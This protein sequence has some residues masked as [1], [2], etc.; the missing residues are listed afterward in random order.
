MIVFY[1]PKIVKR[2]RSC[3]FPLSLLHVAA[4]LPPDQYE[5][6][7]GNIDPNPRS[8][9]AA[10]VESRN[11]I[12]VLAVTVMPGP[13]VVSALRDCQW[14]RRRFP[15]IP[16]LWGGYFPSLYSRAALNAPYVDFLVRG[17]G[18][19][20]FV[21]F[22]RQHRNGKNYAAIP[23]FSFKRHGEQVHNS[24]DPWK[25]PDEFPELL[26]YQKIKAEDYIHPSFL[27]KR[28]A[29]H[30]A[31]IGCPFR[32]N[33]C[34]VISVFGNRQKM[35]A[36]ERTAR[37]LHYLQENFQVDSIQFYDNNFFLAED[38]TIELCERFIPLKINWWCEGR[39]DILLRY[40]DS[41]W[42]KLQ[43][44]G[45]RMIFCGAESG[46]DRSLQEMDKQLTTAQTLQLARRARS[47]GII[48]EF[49][50]I[51]GNPEKPRPEAEETVR[52]IYQLKEIN[53]DCEI[54]LYHYTP[55]PQRN[56]GYGDVEKDLRFPQ[57]VEEWARPEWVRFASHYDPDVPWLKSDLRSWARNFET[58]LKAYWP[59]IQDYRQTVTTRRWLRRLSGWR[60]RAGIYHAP[61]ELK[62]ALR[63]LSLRNPREE[64][65]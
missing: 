16:I 5:I 55:T 30:H 13:Q 62:I 42:K 51:L 53:A 22:L 36:P 15:R 50:F 58:V 52:F 60:Y 57:T 9:L 59:S 20:S 33:F 18:E 29:V 35:A 43:A 32:C 27:G 46:S 40:R 23:G 47:Y 14:V 31:G 61:I 41:T 48:P 6:V 37:A 44:S 24:L 19:D 63:L 49:S 39:I 2:R 64:S 34:G 7:D 8:T 45:C 4:M 28:T 65:L 1:N 12:E 21:E 17:Q 56:G 3:R 26:P 25:S 38:H 11:D 54:I 10:L